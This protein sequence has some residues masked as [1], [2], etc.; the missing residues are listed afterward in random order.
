MQI[1]LN[2]ENPR[3]VI[4]SLPP[5]AHLTYEQPGP[6][7]I[8]FDQL[9]P[10]QKLTIQGGI[11][12]KMITVD[13]ESQLR[14][15]QATQPKPVV[16]APA[17]SP[18][19]QVPLALNMEAVRKEALARAD[20][21]LKTDVASIKKLVL[22]SRDILFLRLMKEQELAGKARK[23]ILST[24][25]KVLLALQ[26]NVIITVGPEDVAKVKVKTGDLEDQFEVEESEFAQIELKP[27]EHSV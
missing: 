5:H 10:A 16:Q 12:W 7:E 19:P 2:V 23:G 22:T 4:W 15:S 26:G 18:T 25:E 21:V 20:A 8:D 17:K 13:P 11:N 24:I 27:S 6:V 3:A 1:T 9:T 14:L